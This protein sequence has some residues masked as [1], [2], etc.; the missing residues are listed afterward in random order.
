MERDEVVFACAVDEL[1]CIV[2]NLFAVLDAP[3]DVLNSEGGL[4][5]C[6]ETHSGKRGVLAIHK[7][8][9]CFHGNK[10]D[11]DAV[12]G[13]VCLERKCKHG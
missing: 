7:D 1:S 13:K 9:C 8:F 10:T 11:L 5:I 4:V 12:R 3:C 2:G 6:G